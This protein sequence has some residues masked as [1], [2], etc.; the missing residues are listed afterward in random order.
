M[1]A[2]LKGGSAARK[3][4]GH[5]GGTPIRPCRGHRPSTHDR[6]DRFHWVI[7][8]RRQVTNVDSNSGVRRIRGDAGRLRQS[9]GPDKPDFASRVQCRHHHRHLFEWCA[10]IAGSGHGVDVVFPGHRPAR[11]AL[12]LC[13]RYQLRA[14]RMPDD[15]DGRFGEHVRGPT[16]A[17]QRHRPQ[18]GRALHAGEYRRTAVHARHHRRTD[19]IDYAGGAIAPGKSLRRRLPRPAPPDNIRIEHLQPDGRIDGHEP[20]L[21]RRRIAPG[22]IARPAGRVQRGAVSQ[23]SCGRS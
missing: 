17:G 11:P 13:R 8:Q 22:R 23:Y 16:V 3:R 2:S 4:Q 15:V 9:G 6:C 14:G 18:S 21:V 5:V 10:G 20:Y 1:A 12:G 7:V 19:G